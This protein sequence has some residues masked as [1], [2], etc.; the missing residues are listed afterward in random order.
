[1]S[2]VKNMWSKLQSLTKTA[3]TISVLQ[4]QDF[5]SRLET[6]TAGSKFI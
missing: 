3:N 4:S 2:E 5:I 1:M 6:K